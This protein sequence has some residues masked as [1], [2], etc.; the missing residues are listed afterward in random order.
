MGGKFGA[1]HGVDVGLAFHNSSGEITG[2]GSVDGALMAD[3]LASAWVAFA[4][5]GNPN[6]PEIPE[7]PAY[8]AQLKPTM[9]FDLETRVEEDPLAELRTFWE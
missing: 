3:R 7:W 2:S 8:D 1:V 5:T 4:R 9:I 6:N